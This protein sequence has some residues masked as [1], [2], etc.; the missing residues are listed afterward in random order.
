M[1]K[2]TRDMRRYNTM[3]AVL[4]HIKD[5]SC[6]SFDD[7]SV[8]T[9]GSYDSR[10]AI[11]EELKRLQYERLIDS[12]LE[13][14]NSNACLSGVVHGLTEDGESLVRLIEQSDVWKICIATLTQA[15]I[16]LSYPLLKEVCEEVVRRYVMSKIPTEM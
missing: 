10:E 12:S 14:D 16:D 4:L 7:F 15:E 13:F 11:I 1:F 8:L 9:H 3:R 5:K 6:L 2:E